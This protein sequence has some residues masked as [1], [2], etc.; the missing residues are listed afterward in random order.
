M[1]AATEGCLRCVQHFVDVEHID[2]RVQSHSQKY[3]ALDF[4]V[5]A[6]SRGVAGADDVA[7]FLRTRLSV[8]AESRGV[9]AAEGSGIQ[10]AADPSSAPGRPL[11][12]PGASHPPVKKRRGQR[13]YWMLQAAAEGCKS[14]VQYYVEEEDLDPSSRSENAK[15]TAL[16]WA[17]WAASNGVD[18][19]SGVAEYLRELAPE[20]PEQ[21]A[22]P[23]TGRRLCCLGESH[24][25]GRKRS[26]SK[27]NWMFQAAAEGCKTCVRYYVRIEKVDPLSQSE[28]A[29]YTALD[30]ANWAASKGV[31]GA[32]EVAEFLLEESDGWELVSHSG[33][34]QETAAREAG[35]STPLTNNVGAGMMAQM[36]WAAGQ[37]LG[38]RADSGARMEPVRPDT[39][40]CGTS[41]RGVGYV[42]KK[43]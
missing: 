16:D 38:P 1:Q 15:Y 11:C 2:P 33:V 4:A 8:D 29:K 27:A 39:S 40:R 13:V 32:S 3:T 6:H 26:R 28:N 19:A 25:P 18:G 14:C 35:L 31:A 5:Y 24:P 37:P 12:D 36:G 21:A 41:L 43:D 10:S 20:L 23:A 30:W 9:G 42:Y 34:S 7:E 17:T 22:N